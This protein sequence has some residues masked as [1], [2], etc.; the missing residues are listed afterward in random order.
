MPKPLPNGKEGFPPGHHYSTARPDEPHQVTV[1]PD[2][3]TPPTY[4]VHGYVAKFKVTVGRTETVTVRHYD[5][6]TH[7]LV[8]EEEVELDGPTDIERPAG[9]YVSVKGA[10][11]ASVDVDKDFGEG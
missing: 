11:G 6:Q 9:S 4:Y 5:P 8:R 2:G 1:G 3:W 10:V 7:A